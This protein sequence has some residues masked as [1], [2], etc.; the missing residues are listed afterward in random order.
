M[1]R[2]SPCLKSYSQDQDKAVE[3]AQTIA[4]VRERL[5]ALPLAILAETRRIDHGRLGIPV[6]LSICG[7]DAKA[8]M[9]TRKQMGKGASPMQAEASALM[10]LMERYG[11]FTFWQHL[12]GAVHTTWSE[13]EQRF[14]R[15]LM[16]LEEISK[17]CHDTLPPA[18]TRRI[19]DLRSWIFMPA[20]RIADGSLCHVPLDLFKQLGEFNGSSAGNTDVESLLQ[21]A[22]ELVERHTCCLADRDQPIL[23]TIDSSPDKAG[24]PVL[25]ELLHKFQQN[26]ITLVLKDFS[27]DMPVPTVAALAYDTTNFPGKSEIVFTAGTASNPVK[28]AVRAI[29]EV[30]Q[31][32]GDF[33]NASCY[34]ASGLPKY[35]ALEQA[36]WLRHGPLVP[37]SSLPSVES[38]DIFDELRAL[39]EGLHSRQFTLY[40]VSTTNPDTLV[41]SHYSFVPGFRFRE[42]D[43]NTSLGL[44]VGRM[45]CEEA[46]SPGK[47]AASLQVVADIYPDAHFLPFFKGMLALRA[48]NRLSARRLF[49]QAE[50]IQPGSDAKALAAFYH[51]YVCTLDEDWSGALPGLNRAAGLCPDMKEFLNL[52]GV[53]LFKLQ[54][55]EEAAADFKDILT[56]LDKGSAVDIQ[57][58][59]LCHK[60]MGNL[61]Q[62]R[63]YLSAA[64]TLDPGLEKAGEHFATLLR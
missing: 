25:A 14:G 53:C 37:L 62:A 64:L 42:R 49:A 35:A 43:K 21:G 22:C 38:D 4:R 2:L 55:Y 48:D 34:E 20:T 12:P 40:A 15:T 46:D 17:A 19:M 58:L 50:D 51:A 52:R 60:F 41:P 5:A 54:R 28:A 61:E 57:N 63:H 8:V 39:A 32:A 16:P 31:L 47:A 56:R 3:P 27:M 26:G 11:F 33:I 45:L 30:A 1:I 23:P 9:P 44:F 7:P 6:Y 59:G 18:E 10:E 13:A 29:T 24:D 36:D